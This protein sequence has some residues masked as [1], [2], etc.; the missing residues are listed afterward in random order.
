M[1]KC[2][3]SLWN[4]D[5]MN[6]FINGFSP[7]TIDQN[8]N[9]NKNQCEKVFVF[10]H[11]F[12]VIRIRNDNREWPFIKSMWIDKRAKS[13]LINGGKKRNG[14]C[15]ANLT[16]RKKLWKK[17]K[18]ANFDWRIKWRDAIASFRFHFMDARA[19]TCSQFHPLAWMY[20]AATEF[21]KITI[22]WSNRFTHC[23]LATIFGA[24]NHMEC[25]DQ[26]LRK[27]LFEWM[28]RKRIRRRRPRKLSIW[29]TTL[30]FSLVLVI[31]A[32]IHHS[33]VHKRKKKKEQK[34]RYWLSMTK[35]TRDNRR[36]NHSPF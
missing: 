10:S 14:K 8:N 18:V 9:T 25:C 20:R 21:A 36:T 26:R 6:M 34:Y 3:F 35:F 30:H 2:R 5:E 12:V 1:A 31:N 13:D 4:S 23:L 29:M 33:C 28:K 24:L 32:E 17:V 7:M 16:M 27:R 11:H 22:Q 19:H 15:C